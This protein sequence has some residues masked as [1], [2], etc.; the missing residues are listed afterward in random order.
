MEYVAEVVFYKTTEIEITNLGD[1]VRRTAEGLREPA[2]EMTVKGSRA[3]VG[4]VI[5]GAGTA[6]EM[7][8][9]Q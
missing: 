2:G 7:E 5:S 9:E 8:T 6:F 1:A 3:F 4:S